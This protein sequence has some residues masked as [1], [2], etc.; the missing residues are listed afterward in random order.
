MFFL[1]DLTIY[2]GFENQYL[3]WAFALVPFLLDCSLTALVC[4][5]ETRTQILGNLCKWYV[6]CQVKKKKKWKDTFL[7]KLAGDYPRFPVIQYWFSFVASLWPNTKMSSAPSTV[8]SL[9]AED[10]VV[11][12]LMLVVST[13]IGIYYAW[14]SR[15]SKSSRDFLMGDRR[16]TAL[17]VSMSLT[18]SFMSSITVLSNP[19]EVGCSYIRTRKKSWSS[20]LYSHF[21]YWLKGCFQV[22]KQ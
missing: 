10:Y 9:V 11:F 3:T 1:N 22:V 20:I 5:A 6:N 7:F 19:A 17:P 21:S 18:A 13:A 15:G 14:A 16:L 8:G 12:A 4:Y 2:W